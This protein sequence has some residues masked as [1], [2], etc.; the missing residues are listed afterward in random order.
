MSCNVD[1]EKVLE[2]ARRVLRI[3][4][5]SLEALR[6]RLGAEFGVAVDLLCTCRG[7]VVFAGM[8]KS[9]LVCRKI[10]ATFASTGTPSLF[11]HPAEGGH[12]DLGMLA[13]GDVLVA[14]SNSGETQELIRLLPAVKRLGIPVI[15]MTGGA[16]STLAAR[17]DVVLDIS[18]IEEACPLNLAPTASTTVT[19][20]LGDALAVALLEARGFTED[21]FAFFHPI[22]ALGRRLLTVSEI[23]HVGDEIPRVD[24]GTIMREA[25][26]EITSKQLGFT[27]VLDGDDRLLGI[28]T[29]GDLR[30]CLENR[31]DPLSLTAGQV[32]TPSPKVIHADALAAKALQMME[33]NKIMSLVIVDSENVV[34]GVIHM[35][36]MLKAGIA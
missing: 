3:E 7:R 15:S 32:M 23:M 4:E 27:T 10:A 35:H 24:P 30:R 29:D 11:L 33:S 13:R 9:G 5:A 21:D 36:D 8:G 34:V 14:V 25:L 28:I 17:A 19:M 12:G 22:G 31:S 20:A 18:V 1:H 26:F 16:S 6:L 2:S